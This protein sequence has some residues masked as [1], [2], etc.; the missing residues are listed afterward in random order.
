MSLTLTPLQTDSFNRA[1]VNPLTAPWALDE[2]NDYGFQIA[3]EIC[4]AGG[5]NNICE[6][7]FTY[8]GT[9]NDCYCTVILVTLAA[10]SSFFYLKIR[11]TDNGQPFFSQ[12]GYRFHVAVGGA[13]NLYVDTAS[14]HTSI[15]SGTGLTINSGDTFTIAAVGTT[16]YVFQNSTQLGSVVDSTYASGSVQL[17]GEAVSSTS[18]LQFSSFVMGSAAVVTSYS[19]SGSAGVA[20]ATVSYSG[21]ASGSVTAN[22]SGN[23]T[24]S[25]LANGSY[26]LTPSKTGYTFSPTSANE[27]VSSS[28]IT[29]VNFTATANSPSLGGGYGFYLA[30]PLSR[31]ILVAGRSVKPDTRPEIMKRP[32]YRPGK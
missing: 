18:N 23:Y 10:A 21:T 13:W 20:G 19:I 32:L 6:Q 8:A 4:E 15:L 31:R 7:Y 16:L 28:N 1:N 27:T 30:E 24:I 14:S 11:A 29:G 25:G 22:G 3:S 17:G 26:T 5:S 9:P 2:A 12:L